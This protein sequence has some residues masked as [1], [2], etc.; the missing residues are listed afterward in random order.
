[1][2]RALRPPNVES[3]KS[4]SGGNVRLPGTPFLKQWWGWADPSAV[5]KGFGHRLRARVASEQGFTLIEVLVSALLVVLISAAVAEAL[6]TSGDFTA[7]TRSHAQANVVAEQDQERMKAMSD[8]LLTALHQTRTVTLNN[9]QYTVTS[10]ATFLNATGGSSCTSRGAAYFKLTSTVTWAGAVGGSAKSVTEESLITRSLAGTMV[11]TAND[12]TASPLA[13]VTI[14]ASGQNT[15]YAAEATTDQNGCVAFAGLPSDSFT[16]TYTDLGYVDVNGDSS[17]TQTQSVNQTSTAAANTE[18]MGLAGS[19]KPS[20][21]TENSAHTALTVSGYELSY[22]GSG[23]GNKMTAAKTVGSQTAPGTLTATSLF[24]FWASSS[25]TYTNNY[26]L[27][28]GACEQEQ[29]LVPPTG[30]GTATVPPGTAVVAASGGTPSV[31]EPAIDVA[32]KYNGSYVTPG[33][34]WVTFT[35]SG[36]GGACS[37]KWQNIPVAGT[38]LV[39]GVTNYI[40][41]A[42]FASNAA[43]GASNASATGDPG[44]ISVCVQYTTGTTTR[45]ESTTAMT[46]TNFTAPTPLPATMD[47]KNDTTSGTGHTASA[48]GPCT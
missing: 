10:T 45:H 27:W 40:Y 26:Q 29:P 36:T 21:Y 8:T 14:N 6:V 1:M 15:G 31:A 41:P 20:F 25:T 11:A 34:V 37:D 24:P 39:S 35:G 38:E 2:L 33:Q 13:G 19:V 16:L 18:V 17:P 12:Q 5:N 23:N 47:L 43:V 9:T 28:A 3:S 42:P 46:N 32:V 4:P 7:F 44:T 22:Y 48:S 30:S